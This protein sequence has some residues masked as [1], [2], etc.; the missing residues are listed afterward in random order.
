MMA[1]EEFYILKAIKPLLL[2]DIAEVI[3]ATTPTQPVDLTDI[4]WFTN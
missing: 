2:V 4:D 1:M 3:Y